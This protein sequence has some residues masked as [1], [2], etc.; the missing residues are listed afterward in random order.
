MQLEKWHKKRN[1]QIQADSKSAR[2]IGLSIKELQQ[3]L[4]KDKKNK[5]K[6][7]GKFKERRAFNKLPEFSAKMEFWCDHCQIDFVAPAWKQWIVYSGI[8]TWQSFCPICEGWVYR[9]ITA[10]VLD[11]YYFKS[12]KVRN[13]RGINAED[14][15][16]PGQYGFKTYYGDPFVNHYMK[17][18]HRHELLFN[19]YASMGLVGKT[20][21]QRAEE[22]DLD[23]EDFE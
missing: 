12:E 2:D 11:P 10:K 15:I 13:M 6:E 17:F 9:H 7:K 21:E 20:L 3:D 19:K 8:G 18:Q 14:L 22:E 4:E 16:Q 1:V 23:D 5:L